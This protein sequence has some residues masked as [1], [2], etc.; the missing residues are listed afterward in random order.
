[1]EVKIPP[2]VGPGIPVMRPPATPRVAGPRPARTEVD[3]SVNLREVLR[4]LRR[5]VLLVALSALVFAVVAAYLAY[6]EPPTY[7]ST[8]TVRMADLRQDLTGG[9]D[10]QVPERIAGPRR[11]PLL[12]QIQVLR[13][14]TLVG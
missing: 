1:M 4:L 2:R 8:A 14:R 11:D 5:N 7:E 9:I 12:S 10:A 6:S 13:S 3:E